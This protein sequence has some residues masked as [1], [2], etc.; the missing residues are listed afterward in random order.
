[1]NKERGKMIMDLWTDIFEYEFETE[2]NADNDWTDSSLDVAV[3][4]VFAV[5]D[6][7][8]F[9]CVGGDF[10]GYVSEFYKRLPDSRT[11]WTKLVL[12]GEAGDASGGGS[13]GGSADSVEPKAEDVAA[14]SAEE[15]APVRKADEPYV[16]KTMDYT[17]SSEAVLKTTENKTTTI[18]GRYIPDMIVVLEKTGN[19]PTEGAGE[20][21][22]GF[23]VLNKDTD[24]KGDAFWKTYNEPW[25][26]AAIA[27]GDVFI[28]ATPPTK[29]SLTPLN[30]KTGKRE[31]SMFGREYNYLTDP[32][33][34]YKYDE[35][36]KT[37]TKA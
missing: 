2:F 18:L 3:S 28:L 25:L 5:D 22:G 27:R 4:E 16:E 20:N 14:K 21:T 29:N 9:T 8:D 34:G 26:D 6:N 36:T 19:K 15:A 37:M 10:F 30:K 12:K 31:V 33:N 7:G 17:P 32:A 35:K 23:N 13:G 11:S 24:L 1:M